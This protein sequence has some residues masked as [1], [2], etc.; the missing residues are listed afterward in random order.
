MKNLLCESKKRSFA[1]LR[2][3]RS[4]GLRMTGGES[5]GWQGVG[6]GDGRE[7]DAQNDKRGTRA[8]FLVAERE[9]VLCLHND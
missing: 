7:R 2:M 3:T 6:A 9:A 4:E 1:P 8:S 5:S